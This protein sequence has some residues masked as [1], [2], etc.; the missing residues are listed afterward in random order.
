MSSMSPKRGAGRK[1]G[2]YEGFIVPEKSRRQEKRSPRRG[3]GAR[4]GEL[5]EKKVTMKSS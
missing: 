5:E 2:H 4:K 1:K 3:H